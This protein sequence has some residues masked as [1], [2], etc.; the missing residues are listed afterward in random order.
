MDRKTFDRN[1]IKIAAFDLD[2]T[3]LLNGQ[4]RPAVK[5]ALW[6][7]RASGIIPVVSTGR[8]KSMVV[9]EVASCFQAGSYLNGGYCEAEDGTAISVNP[10]DKSKVEDLFLKVREAG[11]EGFFFTSEKRV[12]SERCYSISMNWALQHQK[13]EYYNLVKSVHDMWK[14]DLVEDTL[15]ALRQETRPVVKVETN[16]P[17]TE[18]KYEFADYS[19]HVLGFETAIMDKMSLEITAGGVT[20]ATGVKSI[21]EHYGYGLENVVAFGDSSNDL[22]MLRSCGYA[23][24]MGKADDQIK[25]CAHYIAPPV[26]EDG[27]ATAIR[28]LFSL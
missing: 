26:T 2:N 8:C 1:R 20:K 28:T 11:G 22:A 25:Q 4:M 10:M 19:T 3:V 14:A 16:F 6:D 24:A 15:Q 18:L 17:Q 23:V 5:Q 21:A 12:V 27:A 7:L 13:I 9:P